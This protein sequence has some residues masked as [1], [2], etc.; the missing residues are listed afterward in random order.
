VNNSLLE[1]FPGILGVGGLLIFLVALSVSL[2]LPLIAI[3][4]DAEDTATIEDLAANPENSGLA[5]LAEMFPEVVSDIYPEGATPANYADAL[6]RGRDLYIDNACFQC[7]TQNVRPFETDYY[8]PAAS[9]REQNNDLMHPVLIG[10]RRVGPDLSRYGGTRETAWLVNYLYDPTALVSEAVAMPAY[11][12]F[13]EE[14][15]DLIEDPEAQCVPNEDGIA[16]IAYLQ[17]LGDYQP[18]GALEQG[19][20][21]DTQ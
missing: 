15:C 20:E 3:F 21:G 4:G 5:D 13:Y 14:G 9:P 1:R 17:W 11:P 19:T 16:I 10:T 18:V 2:V 7:H 12:W 8:G 6:E